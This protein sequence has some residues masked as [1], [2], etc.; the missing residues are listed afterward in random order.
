MVFNDGGVFGV[1]DDA[2][3]LVMEVVMEVVVDGF[4]GE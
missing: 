2:C 1:D 3:G 4:E